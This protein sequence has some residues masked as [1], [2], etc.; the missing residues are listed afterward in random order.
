ML[1]GGSQFTLFGT[2]E[3]MGKGRVYVYPFDLW[4]KKSKNLGCPLG[5][6]VLKKNQSTGSKIL[7]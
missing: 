1:L 3:V 6:E 7:P 5:P 4:L 2:R